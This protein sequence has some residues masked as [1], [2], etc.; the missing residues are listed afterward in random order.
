MMVLIVAAVSLWVAG[1]GIF[2]LISPGGLA[3]LVSRWESKRGLWLASIVRLGFG[4]ALWLV[5]PSS[6]TPVILR[7][8]AVITVAAGL[9]LPFLGF[10]R[11]KSL[12][13]WWRRRSPAFVRAWAAV[14]MVMGGFIL[15]S[16]LG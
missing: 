13:S 8:L 1:M 10:S 3:S 9:A 7:V 5:A 15:W 14:A 16:V 4:I 12:L 6:R 11:F 2:G